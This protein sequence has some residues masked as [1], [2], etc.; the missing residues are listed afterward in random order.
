MDV[1]GRR[2]DR[3]RDASLVHHGDPVGEGEEF[4]QL[5]GDQQ[6][7]GAAFAQL[8]E[9]LV[10]P[11]DRADVQATSRLDRDQERWGG[12]DLAREDD[13]LQ[14]AARQ[15]PDG[16]VDRRRGDLVG[17][18]QSR[19]DRPGRLVVHE[20]AGGDRLVPVVLHHQVVDDGQV[21][22]TP[23]PG[24]V[25]GHVPD[26]RVDRV[27][28]WSVR[29]VGAVDGD[30]ALARPQARDRLG[31]FR[32]AIAGHRRDP[33]DLARV[34]V[35]RDVAKGRQATIVLR[36]DTT[37]RQD[38]A[39]AFDRGTIEH[40]EHRPTDH[41]P[42]EIGATRARGED[43]R[44]GHPTSTHHGDPIGDG[45]HLAELV[46]DE[47]DA[48]SRSRHRPERDEELLGLLGREHGRR[49]VHDQDP[50]PRDRAS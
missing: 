15:D 8:Q 22:R 37:D 2:V 49:L 3:R 48:S 10:D 47:D 9:R 4:L 14:V 11:L 7:G 1:R 50:A 13:S 42:G 43:V 28:R 39:T 24:A 27:A 36:R 32:L 38:D 41:E 46:A 19:R 35:Q 12:V 26:A 16:R 45:Q 25:L 17:R 40:L 31:E 33:D 34:D 44:R 29:D 5:L 20:P 21:G 18:E 23:D 30:P 6:D